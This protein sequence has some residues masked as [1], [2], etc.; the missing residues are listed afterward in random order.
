MTFETPTND[1][2]D[3]GDGWHERRLP[4]TADRPIE[5]TISNPNGQVTVRAGDRD[6]ALIRFI[7]RSRYADRDNRRDGV[8]ITA[9]GNRIV[10]RVDPHRAGKGWSGD[11]AADA[12]AG[13]FA[14]ASA[15]PG[16]VLAEASRV[17]AEVGQLFASASHDFQIDLE[18]ELPRRSDSR[19]AVATASGGI[20][21]SGI[22]GSIVVT[23]ASGDARLVDG[24]GQMQLKTTSGDLQLEQI[25]GT[26]QALTTSGDLHLTGAHLDQFSVQSVSGDLLLETTLR[27]ASDSTAKTVSGDVMLRLATAEETLTGLTL[28][29]QTVSGDTTIDPAFRKV[30]RRT[31]RIGEERDGSRLAIQTVSG[32][33]QIRLGVSPTAARPALPVSPVAPATPTAAPAAPVIPAPPSPPSPESAATAAPGQAEETPT[34]SATAAPPENEATRLAVLEAVERGEIDVEEALRRLDPD[35]EQDREPPLTP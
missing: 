13:A 35:S 19:L 30:D 25:Q 14:S 17:L 27:G 16:S 26:L 15:K 9:D 21:L 32:D 6:D 1:Q 24:Q 3:R 10:V 2:A 12:G 8:K 7:Q 23:S 4:L 18:V 28:T 22:D 20:D 33:L 5:L 29:Y 11:V 31:W 34:R